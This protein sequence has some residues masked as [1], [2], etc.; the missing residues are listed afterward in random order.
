MGE[1][2]EPGEE[3]QTHRLSGVSALREGLNSL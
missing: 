3:F 2:G 1:G